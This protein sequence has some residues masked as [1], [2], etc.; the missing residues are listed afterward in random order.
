LLTAQGGGGHLGLGGEQVWTMTKTKETLAPGKP[1]LDKAAARERTSAKPPV[2][3]LA[4]LAKDGQRRKAERGRTDLSES[5]ENSFN[6]QHHRRK[7]LAYISYNLSK[8]AESQTG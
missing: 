5:G 8:T 6:G 1:A 3:P 4:A 2:A 7:L